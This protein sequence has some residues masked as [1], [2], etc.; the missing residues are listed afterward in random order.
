MTFCPA[1]NKIKSSMVLR[2]IRLI[3]TVFLMLGSL[4]AQR[5]ITTIA[6]TD[7]LFPGDG[8]PA[9]AAPLSANFGL[10]LKTDSNGNFFVCD[11][12][13]GV[14]I[15]VGSDGI[16]NVVAGNGFRSFVSGDGGPAVNA[17]LGQAISIALD[18][19]GN[20]YIGEYG[21]IIRKVTPDGIIR[22]IAGGLA[23]GFSGDNGPA[24][25]AL[26]DV[27]RGLAVDPNGVIYIADSNNQRI[28]KITTDGII[29]TIAGTGAIGRTGDG[30]Q[31][32]AAHLNSPT[33]IATDNTGNIFFVDLLNGVLRKIDNQGVITTVAGGGSDLGEGVPATQ[34]ALAVH[35]VGR[36]S[37]GNL[38][39]TD[40]F[41][42]G[43]RKID[44]NGL[45]RTVAGGSGIKGFSGDGGPALKAQFSLG[46]YTA[47][48]VD[49]N[50]NI[51]IAD[52]V[53]GRIR[54]VD[55]SGTI[56]TVAGNNLFHFSGDGGPA[57]SATLD[58][59][60]GVVGDSN[61][62]LFVAEILYNR[63]RR[64]APDGTI[65]VY[66]GN[67]QLGFSGD[68][69]P[70]VQ[71]KLAYPDYLAI[72]PDGALIFSDFLN[73]V[74]R[75]VDLQGIISTIAGTPGFCQ[76]AGDSGPPLKA[77]FYAPAGVA[78]DA[79]GEIFITD[80]SDNRIRVVFTPTGQPTEV[81]TIAGNGTAGFAG[82]NDSTFKSQVNDPEGGKV[83]NGA[84]YFA[85]SKNHRIRRIDFSTLVITTV[86]GNG[87][88]AYAGDGGQA[89]SAS[90]KLPSSLAFDSSGNMY[91]SD[92]GNAAIR[93]VTPA[94]IIS[95]LAG[96][97][98]NG[99]LGDGG[100]ANQAFIGSP[101][102]VY[103]DAA[104]NVYLTD[105][106]SN[107]V[108]AILVDK[109]S[110][111]FAPANLSFTAPAGSVAT[112]QRI[113]LSGS[114][115]GV[116]FMA[117]GGSSWLQISPTIGNMPA[118]LR[119]TADASSL[120]AGTYNSTVT[121]TTANANP[122]SQSIP[123]SFTVTATGQPSLS[124]TPSALTFSAVR[125]SAVK[126]KQIVASNLGGGS[127][128]F[129]TTAA[130]GAWLTASPSS[131]TLSAF[132]STP[133]T[134]AA[135]P[136]G[137]SA[138]TYSGT[139]AVASGALGQKITVA[140]TM[141]VSAVQ[142]TILIPQT[143]L[144]F[145]ALQGGGQTLP[146]FFSILN[147]GQ[148]QMTWRVTASTL[149]GGSWLAAFPSSGVTD[150]SSPIVPQ[151]RV[152]ADPGSLGVGTYYGTIQVTAPSADNTP[153]FVSAVLTV[154]PAGTNLG[155]LVQPAGLIFT[156]VT[157]SASPGSQSI[158]LQNTSS[159]TLQFHASSVT[160]DGTPWFAVLP[161]D[162]TLTQA[163]PM[164]I[165][166]QP[167]TGKLQAGIRRATLTLAFSDGS[168]RVVALVLVL[169]GPGGSANA[170]STSHANGCTPIVLAPVFT[171]LSDG[172]QVPA[173]FPAQVTTKVVD[174]C[175][176]PMTTGTVVVSFDNGDQPLS[177][178]SLKDGT[179]A[180]TW[181][182]QHPVSPITITAKASVPVQNLN[183][184]VQIKV[185]LAT[186][187]RQQQP[188]S[189]GAVINNASQTV[190]TPLAPGMLVA[191]Y[192]S[193]LADSATSASSLPLPNTLANGSIQIAGRSAPLIYASNGQ[194]NAFL[195]YGLAVN[196]SQQVLASRGG[197]LS[198][199]MAVTIA[200]AAPG[201]YSI[202][203]TGKGQGAILGPDGK[204]LADA[205]H[206]VKV[207]EVIVIFCTGLGELDNPV[208]AGMPAP[209]APLSRTAN[210]VTATIG[211]LPAQ[212]A[213]AGLSPG[214]AGLYQVNVTIPTGVAA[215]SQVPVTISAA[216]QT[217]A[218]VTIAVK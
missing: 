30:G 122:P 195:P 173:G 163:Q 57:T 32:T 170:A 121:L 49:S 86:A 40:G 87:L 179:W 51:D 8:R 77:S 91:I 37:A 29:H 105:I 199:P 6:G 7:W 189:I 10:D 107:R 177:L 46:L 89:T 93:M 176:N 119:I 145:F 43:V 211:G 186:I 68:G 12:A 111:Q 50:G 21:G 144:A 76:A 71:A 146:Q 106:F 210:T 84:F 74:V 169:T 139:V 159:N 62:N 45:I 15:K 92:Q 166:I 55:P 85:D 18:H 124:V 66:A 33:S 185:G 113:D 209:S 183:G 90:L 99:I 171:M 165:V 137:L 154:L 130:G 158:V 36:D 64:I 141:T 142:Q 88:A 24:V 217:S 197:N 102:D 135:D 54:S 95:T 25:N 196:T 155:A 118:S 78:V 182:P 131:G 48:A 153:Q 184:K 162:G 110:Y 164:R 112:E 181:T 133:L 194:V 203:S 214:F 97:V 115:S 207:G 81:I 65:S 70:A 161:P 75:R 5:V 61:G 157:G 190:N 59:P 94:G 39:I 116:P 200:A 22:T 27:V 17:A 174:D 168:R 188:T 96:A 126:T 104:G 2:F 193:Q 3:M 1:L 41:R 172:F 152:D 150:A 198:S 160:D 151:V 73:C 47:L 13:N 14:V 143:G 20:L 206:P 128:P 187:Q 167:Q 136:T 192:G 125:N 11:T 63:I 100:P 204:T 114:I 19:N 138:G 60:A 23:S 175:A 69:G 42:Q 98:L 132:G 82:D 140:V 67:G 120:A 134:I 205:S 208:A 123:I 156:G 202:D 80:S 31:A 108:R 52:V 26:L 35:A 4:W 44:L 117:S 72:A 180:A 191:V 28:R 149:S 213:F 83:Y 16:A 9:I 218:T 58:E 127:V 201:I 101:A 79:L 103:A 215:G 129:T 34:A 38:Y 216:G 56:R 109:P 147:T 178:T 212:V 148:G 53:N